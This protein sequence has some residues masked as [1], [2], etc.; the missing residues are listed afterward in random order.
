[1]YIHDILF[2]ITSSG[3]CALFYKKNLSGLEAFPDVISQ[4]R[5]FKLL[6]RLFIHL[7][8][9]IEGFGGITFS[10]TGNFIFPPYLYF[11]S[12]IAARYNR[13][14]K[15]IT[16][17]YVKVAGSGFGILLLKCDGTRAETRFRLS[18]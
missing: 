11:V 2:K 9:Q 10:F 6:Y 14:L 7:R 5:H 15:W 18:A 16:R 8:Q 12:F 1:M 3:S 17:H 13:S 4:M